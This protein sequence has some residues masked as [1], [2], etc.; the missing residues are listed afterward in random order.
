MAVKHTPTNEVHKGTKG[1]KTGCGFDGGKGD[2][3][4]TDYTKPWLSHLEQLQQLK[5]RGLTITDD[6]RALAH[7][8]RIG[9]YRLSG[10]W[11]AFRQRSGACTPLNKYGKPLL[12]K[13]KTDSSW[14]RR[15]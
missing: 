14:I 6:Q 5:D 7:L 13:G 11:F 2:R 15:V 8:Q 10:Y 12:K 9:Y 3:T 4:M 1:G